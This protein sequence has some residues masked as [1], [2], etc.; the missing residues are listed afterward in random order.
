MFFEMLFQ[1]ILLVI[2]MALIAMALFR[3]KLTRLQAPVKW[4]LVVA[5]V[6]MLINFAGRPGDSGRRSDSSSPTPRR[7]LYALSIGVVQVVG[8][9]PTPVCL[10]GL[11]VL[12]IARTPPAKPALD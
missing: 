2:V 1:Q 7:L 11:L 8:S 10:L 12:V 4:L 3:T 6:G 5:I 9:Y